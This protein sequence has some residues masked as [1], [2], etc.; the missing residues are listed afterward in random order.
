MHATS[1]RGRTEAP[2]KLQSP[3]QKSAKNIM[4]TGIETAGLALAIFPL[5][6]R[7]LAFYLDAAQK[8]KEIYKYEG[9]LK[10]L[11]RELEMERSKFENTC[12]V[13][14][15]GM[16]SAEQLAT[17]V[18]GEGWKDPNLQNGLERCLGLNAAKSFTEAVAA[19]N[20]LLDSLRKGIGLD[21]NS[22]VP[23]F[24]SP[25]LRMNS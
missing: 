13:L 2:V 21:E 5:V 25:V 17:L 7:G 19:L 10:R 3:F 11:V 14:L 6:V 12:A 18:S 16:V 8:V 15:E 1:K 24:A 4:V 20:S 22:Q 23:R 9:V